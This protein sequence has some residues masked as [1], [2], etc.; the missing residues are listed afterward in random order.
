[1]KSMAFLRRNGAS[2]LGHVAWA[3]QIYDDVWY[4]GSL[5]QLSGHFYTNNTKANDTSYWTLRKGGGVA[6]ALQ[7]M[8]SCQYANGFLK[9][10]LKSPLTGYDEVII[11]NVKHGKPQDALD[12]TRRWGSFYLVPGANCLN[13][14][15]QIL[16]E[17][18]TY[19]WNFFMPDPKNIQSYVPA[20]WFNDTALHAQARGI[21][22]K[23]IL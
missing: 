4:M 20:M 3:F 15:F 9:S 23:Y 17:F 13:N 1:M 11:F 21:G 5:E 2:G 6:G 18:G 16:S 14:T 12:E 7:E 8:K 19:D 22:K 10:Q